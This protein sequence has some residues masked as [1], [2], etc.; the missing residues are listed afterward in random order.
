MNRS[1]T[2]VVISQV[3]PVTRRTQTVENIRPA[4]KTLSIVIP[5]F[6]EATVIVPVLEELD[7]VLQTL[8]QDCTI[9]VIDD[10]SR[11]ATSKN[12]LQS[13][14]RTPLKLVRLSRNFGKEIAMSAGLKEARNS[15]AVVI[16]DADGQHPPALINDFITYWEQ[17]Y[18]DIYALR[19]SR[20][21]DKW[22]TRNLSK[23]FYKLLPKDAQHIK[24]NAGDF[25]LLSSR[26]VQALNQMPEKNRFMKGL[27]TWVGFKKHAIPYVVRPRLGGD[28]KFT[29][30]SLIRFAITGITSFSTLPL[31]FISRTGFL[32]S[33]LSILYGLHVVLRTLIFGVDLPGWATLTASLTLLSGIQLVSIGV[34]GEYIGQ[35]F[36]ESKNRPL[37]LVEEVIT[38]DAED[39]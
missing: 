8:K 12:A 30:K 34:L 33:G 1:P 23:F 4:K 32:V 10:G 27:Y 18:E 16:M 7:M 26:V 31:Q 38:K 9:I 20:H 3:T 22:L 24:N 14:L 28:T 35:I 39:N 17:G 29:L 11:D 19:E 5:A 21:T 6:N 13:R 15:D 37:Y 2:N 36:I 25:R